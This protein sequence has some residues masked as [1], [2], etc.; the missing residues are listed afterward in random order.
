MLYISNT[1]FFKVASVLINFLMNEASNFAKV[2]RITY[3]S[4]RTKTR[5]GLL[6]CVYIYV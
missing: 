5:C 6:I 2:L 4:Y 1:F 3:R